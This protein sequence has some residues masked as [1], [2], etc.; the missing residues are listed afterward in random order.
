M[1]KSLPGSSTEYIISS[2]RFNTIFAAISK[3]NP[4]SPLISIFSCSA[5]TSSLKFSIWKS[6]NITVSNDFLKQLSSQT[7]KFAEL[8]LQ[9]FI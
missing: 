7:S 2:E 9:F 3:S 1:E 6:P 5:P 8:Y 4:R